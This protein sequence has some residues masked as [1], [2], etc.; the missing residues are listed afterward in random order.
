[1]A[2]NAMTGQEVWKTPT[3][4]AAMGDALVESIHGR[5]VVFVGAGDAGFTLQHAQDFAHH[6]RPPGPTVRGANYSAIYA[7]NGENGKIL[8]RFL[9]PGED[10]PTPVY[11][12]GLLFFSN[13]DG[14]LD[15]L[16]AVSGQLV[17]SF[18]NP[19]FSSMS[20]A[21]WIIP[22][23]GPYQGQFLVIYGTQDPNELMAVD[24]NNPVQPQLAW[25]YKIPHS[26]NTG[27]GDVPPVVD[28]QTDEVITDSLVN[29]IAQGGTARHKILNLDI[30][31]INA[32]TGQPIWSHLGGNGLV[33][34]PPA[35]KGSLPMVHGN[36]VYVGD[37][38]NESYQAYNVQTGQQEWET[39]L[40]KPGEIN[41]PRAGSVYYDHRLL[42]AQGHHIYTINPQTGAI[43]NTFGVRGYYFG[44][45]GIASP[46][47]ISGELYMGSI[48]G[49]VFAAPASYV[50]TH[51]GH[52]LNQPLL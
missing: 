17:S 2:L 3:I 38:L 51:R 5:P 37:L 46:V 24:E 26:V 48:S 31:A 41:E 52:R 21:N 12:D 6:G 36:S 34:R 42:L 49:W 23:S 32:A 33:R 25:T 47:I 13:G 45:W 16:N 50:M 27:A 30:F 43:V 9:T 19:G 10:M 35:F 44:A 4:N 14:Q 15:A 29:D 8:W 11:H 28:P 39:S 40:A 7:I 22:Q 1:D 20:S 18:A